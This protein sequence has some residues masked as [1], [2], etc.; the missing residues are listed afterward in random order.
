[1]WSSRDDGWETWTLDK[2][3]VEQDT[4]QKKANQ[5]VYGSGGNGNRSDLPYNSFNLLV[6]QNG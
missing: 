2:H 1:M 6:E 3:T 4:K 5:R